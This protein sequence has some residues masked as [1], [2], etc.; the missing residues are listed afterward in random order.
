M[1]LRQ[2]L[3]LSEWWTWQHRPDRLRFMWQAVGGSSCLH[4]DTTADSKWLCCTRRCLFCE[5]HQW[6]VSC[7][8][9]GFLELKF[10]TEPSLC[11]AKMLWYSR[12]SFA[13]AV[14]PKE[15][16]WVLR[17]LPSMLLRSFVLVDSEGVG[18][19]NRAQNVIWL[20]VRQRP[21]RSPISEGVSTVG[22]EV[23]GVHTQIRAARMLSCRG[24]TIHERDHYT[25]K[26]KWASMSGSIR[27][28]QHKEIQ[29]ESKTMLTIFRDAEELHLT[30]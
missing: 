24:I 16:A 3:Y 7:L 14:S 2:S 5:F 29:T 1:W 22:V 11:A 26:S 12:E 19:L 20:R 21:W 25:P 6:Y 8:P 23:V 17:A 27:R 10:I 13:G 4:R 15:I 18:I 28:P 9:N 30:H